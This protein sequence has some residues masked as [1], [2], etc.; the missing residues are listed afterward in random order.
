VLDESTA[1][2][3]TSNA[4]TCYEASFPTNGL[5]PGLHSAVVMT[6]WGTSQAF[7]LTVL[8]RV[9]PAPATRIDVQ[10]DYDGDI[11][12]ALAAAAALPTETRKV[13]MLGSATYQLTSGVTVPPTTT[14]VGDGA[15][16]ASLVF[17]IKTGRFHPLLI[18]VYYAVHAL[19]SLWA[20]APC[21]SFPLQSV[22][23]SLCTR[24]CEM[25]VTN[26]ANVCY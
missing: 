22:M 20:H 1:G 25:L 17:T 26:L 12:K 19:R 4:A 10:K 21:Q 24:T 13:V 14:L 23:I 7:G 2:E 5:T 3:V 8:A 11:H 6:P 9:A 15:E 18:L 16:S